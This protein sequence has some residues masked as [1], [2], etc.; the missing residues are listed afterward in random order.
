MARPRGRGRLRR[1]RCRAWRVP[2]PVPVACR[3]GVWRGLRVAWRD[4][5]CGA[6][7]GVAWRGVVWCVVAWGDEV[8]L[9]G[10]RFFRSPA[11]LYSI[12]RTVP[13][14]CGVIDTLG[15]APPG[16]RTEHLRFTCHL[17]GQLSHVTSSG[18]WPGVWCAVWRGAQRVV[19]LGVAGRGVWFSCVAWSV[20]WQW[21]GCG[22]ATPAVALRLWLCPELG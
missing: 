6:A 20:P 2:E 16:A 17:Q 14:G 5:G 19:W 21:V 8:R 13:F 1:S 4:V 15:Q 11:E 10:C 22:V 3:G 7:C 12:P 18:M 9:P